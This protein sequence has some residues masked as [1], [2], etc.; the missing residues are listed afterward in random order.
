MCL[1]RM[2]SITI[3]LFTLGY[4]ISLLQLGCSTRTPFSLDGGMTTDPS[5]A[6]DSDSDSDSD[7]D[8]DTDSDSDS[9]MDIDVDIDSDADS[10]DD[11]DTMLDNNLDTDL[12]LLPICCI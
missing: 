12:A 2:L 6:S 11:S 7:G 5:G 10:D 9:D 8:S 3:R 4:I 1:M